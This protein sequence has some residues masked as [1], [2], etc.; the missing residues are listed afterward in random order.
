MYVILNIKEV[1]MKQKIIVELEK[2]ITNGEK[3]TYRELG[4]RLDTVAST[5]T[6]Q[7]GSKDKL[8]EYY[9]DY[10]FTEAYAA[11]TLNTFTELLVFS[12]QTNN[13]LLGQFKDEITISSLANI[14]TT[15]LEKHQYSFEQ[16]YFNQ[17]GK[18]DASQMMQYMSLIQLMALN[19][20]F[21]GK[22]LDYNPQS[23]TQVENYIVNMSEK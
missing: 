16:L 7:F 10:K 14:Q 18:Q 22:M 15:L 9:L 20:D 3:V 19:P 4:K 1:D 23:Q 8:I 5:I 12:Y 2:M 11:E 17:Y 6:Y 21:Y 13:R